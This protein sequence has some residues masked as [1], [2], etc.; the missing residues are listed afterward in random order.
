MHVSPFAFV[1]HT[2]GAD[3]D[4]RFALAFGNQVVHDEVGTSLVHPCCLVLSPSVLQ[5]EHRELLLSVVCWRKIDKGSWSALANP[6]RIV[7]RSVLRRE[8]HL[9]H[10][11]VRHV[12]I[13]KEILVGTWYLN[14]A[15]PTDGA[16]V[17]LCSWVVHHTTVDGQM[18]VVEAWI[19]RTFSGAC[20][21]SVLTL[22]QHG[23][24]CSAQ[25]EAHY[26]RLGIGSHH[27]EAGITL[28]VHHRVLLSW[29]VEWRRT[30]VFLHH[31]IVDGRIEVLD[32][33]INLLVF[34]VCVERQR[35]V[36][37]ANP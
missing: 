37:H 27:T 16:V 26:H 28:R 30:E 4:E 25:S 14:A 23:A 33:I 15:L 5:V 12:L 21:Y 32:S 20:P 11:S 7:G 9:N 10:L 3:D 22:V 19:H 34:K 6:M 18:I 31:G 17:V 2:I 29:L 35:I 13:G 8:V 1:S 36:V 24:A